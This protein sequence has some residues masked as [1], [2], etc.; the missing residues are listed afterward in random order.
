MVDAG[1]SKLPGGI[2]QSPSGETRVTIYVQVPDLS[3]AIEKAT[4][5]GGSVALPPTKVP[6]G[7]RL[8]Q[9][10]DPDGNLMGLIEA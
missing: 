9:I 3:E 4:K 1:T 6:G 8:A 2:G 10:Q 7:P 5:L